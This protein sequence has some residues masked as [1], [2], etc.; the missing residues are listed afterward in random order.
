MSKGYL[1]NYDQH[2]MPPQS[3]VKSTQIVLRDVHPLVWASFPPQIYRKHFCSVVTSWQEFDCPDHLWSAIIAG[4]V[5]SVDSLDS[6]LQVEEGETVPMAID[7][8]SAYAQRE[9]MLS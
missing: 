1:V 3:G 4:N 5:L 2:R 8:L 7:A 9:R 6:M